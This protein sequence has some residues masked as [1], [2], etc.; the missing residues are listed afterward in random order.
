VRAG[1]RLVEELV[2]LDPRWRPADVAALRRA[3]ELL[4]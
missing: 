3:F 2:D 1:R 4:S